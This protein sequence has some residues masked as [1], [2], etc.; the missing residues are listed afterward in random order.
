MSSIR[1][2]CAIFTVAQDVLEFFFDIPNTEA[3]TKMKGLGFWTL[4]WS[5]DLNN[6]Q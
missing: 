2:T 1:T 6:S 3:I 4:A 5:H